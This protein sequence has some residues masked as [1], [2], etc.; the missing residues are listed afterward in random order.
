LILS[1]S[2]L[3]AGRVRVD[4]EYRDIKE[5]LQLIRRPKMKIDISFEP[6]VRPGDLLTHLLNAEAEILHF[7][8]HASKHGLILE[9]S[10]GNSQLVDEQA[11]ANFVRQTKGVTECVVLNACFT[12]DLAQNVADHISV[13]IGCDSTIDDDDAILFSRAFYQSLAAGKSY[14]ESFHL[15]IADVELNGYASAAKYHILP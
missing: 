13:V 15:A 10:L 6:A 2:P 3:N 7:S 14:K 1:A 4:A 9:D 5:K 8:G 12:R 11:I